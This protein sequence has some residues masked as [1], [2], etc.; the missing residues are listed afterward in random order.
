[1]LQCE[2]WE[3]VDETGTERKSGGRHK[4]ETK[5]APERAARHHSGPRESTKVQLNA[6]ATRSH[7]FAP[8]GDQITTKCAQLFSQALT[9]QRSSI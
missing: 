3:W 4:E 8:G 6:A 2:S 1:M 5:R 7:A 9:T